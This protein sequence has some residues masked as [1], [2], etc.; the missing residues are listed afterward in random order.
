M[1]KVWQKAR[2]HLQAET[3]AWKRNWIMQFI[4]PR[5]EEWPPIKM[6]VWIV[7]FRLYN[8]AFFHAWL[9]QRNRKNSCKSFSTER[10]HFNVTLWYCQTHSFMSVSFRQAWRVASGSSTCSHYAGFYKLHGN[11]SPNI[12]PIIKFQKEYNRCFHFPTVFLVKQW[13]TWYI[14][15][16][17]KYIQFIRKLINYEQLA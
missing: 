10:K 6:S 2:N 3:T 8:W 1:C 16:Q 9:L 11:L 5:H 17:T 4:R 7:W 15:R 12:Y 14:A 13:V